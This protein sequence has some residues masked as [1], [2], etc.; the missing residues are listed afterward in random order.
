MEKTVKDY[1]SKINSRLIAKKNN[2]K[3]WWGD[4][5]K[6]ND[7]KKHVFGSFGER[8][9]NGFMIRTF[10]RKKKLRKNIKNQNDRV[11]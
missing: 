9:C 8:Q 1:G 5:M 7:K 2:G 4:I 10:I 11:K 6:K 3:N